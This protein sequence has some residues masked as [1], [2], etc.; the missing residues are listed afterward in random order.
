LTLEAE[1]KSKQKIEVRAPTGKHG[2]HDDLAGAVVRAIWL[3]HNDTK[4]NPSKHSTSLVGN[5]QVL[6]PNNAGSPIFA[7][8]SFRMQKLKM[9]GDLATQRTASP[10]VGGFA[11]AFPGMM[12]RRGRR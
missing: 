4:E 9:H 7:L 3:C 11:R 1:R 6:L 12:P 2:A 8:S 5:G 10:T